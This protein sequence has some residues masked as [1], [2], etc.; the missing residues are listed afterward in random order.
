MATVILREQIF[1]PHCNVSF[2]LV[3]F[4]KKRLVLDG[5][6]YGLCFTKTITRIFWLCFYLNFSHIHTKLYGDKKGLKLCIIDDL[7]VWKKKLYAMPIL[8]F[9]VSVTN[10]LCQFWGSA[11]YFPSRIDIFWPVVHLLVWSDIHISICT[12]I[13][14]WRTDRRRA[15]YWMVMSYW[16]HH[17]AYTYFVF[18][19]IHIGSGLFGSL[20]LSLLCRNR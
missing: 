9:A 4:F 12:T 5:L 18:I 19:H 14:G 13:K 8:C 2:L 10:M 17:T 1:K 6:Q 20:N 7:S 3:P 11:V 16:I 15:S